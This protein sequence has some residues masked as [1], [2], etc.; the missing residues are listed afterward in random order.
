[1]Y[2]SDLCVAVVL[3]DIA[4][5]LCVECVSLMCELLAWPLLSHDLLSSCHMTD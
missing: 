5:C 1:M 3:S 2:V 4:V